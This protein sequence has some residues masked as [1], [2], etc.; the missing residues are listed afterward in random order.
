MTTLILS[1]GGCPSYPFYPLERVPSYPFLAENPSSEGAT[2]DHLSSKPTRGTP[3]P[4]LKIKVDVK[5]LLTWVGSRAALF[6]TPPGP[7]IQL[8]TKPAFH[9]VIRSSL[10]PTEIPLNLTENPLNL[11][12]RARNQTERIAVSNAA[13]ISEVSKWGWRTE[14]VGAR[15]SLPHHKYRPF[16]C[17]PFSYAPL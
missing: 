4:E 9:L 14:G 13:L 8:A 7:A 2:K 17:P 5:G 16:F 11:T 1:S 12:G 6:R 15:K 3:P 10:N